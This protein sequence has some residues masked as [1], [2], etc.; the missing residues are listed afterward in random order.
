MGAEAVAKLLP[1]GG[2][3][4]LMAGPPNASWARRRVA[5]FLEEIKKH[6]N[7]K[8]LSVVS[9]DNDASDGMT[10][11][12]NA[13]QA[14]PKF[15]FVYVTGSFVLQPQ[16]I[17]AEY[18]KAV[19]VAGSLSPV[20]LEALKDGSAG[21]MLPD[22]PISVGYIVSRLVRS[23]TASLSTQFNCAPNGAMFKS[24]ANDPIWLESNIMPADAA[25]AK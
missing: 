20:A 9:S 6:P 3:G 24:D 21:A 14:N 25:P 11:F 16:S 22:F 23:S 15:D 2:Q 17:P 7:I 8:V 19:Y 13:A 10:K 1:Q 5:G 12:S 4:L 18:R